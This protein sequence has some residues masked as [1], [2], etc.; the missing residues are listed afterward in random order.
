MINRNSVL[1][2]AEA[3]VNHN[4]DMQLAYQLIDAAVDAG[5]DIVKFQTF[6]TELLVNKQAKKADYQI[7]NTGNHNSS[8]Y[9][10]LK[11]LELTEEQHYQLA[12]YCKQKGIKFW[13]TAFDIESVHFLKSMGITLGK[14]PSGEITNLPYLQAMAANFDTLIVSTGMCTTEEVEAAILALENAGARRDKITILHCTTEYPAPLQDVHLNA[15]KAMGNYF[16]MQY[17]YSDHTE[18]IAIPIAAVA[19]GATVIEKHFTLNKNLPGPDHKA[20]LEPHELKAMVAGIRAVEKALGTNLKQPSEVELK[21]KLV[22]RKSICAATD[23]PQGTLIGETHLVMLRPGTGISPM[24][25]DKVL[26]K[27]LQINLSAGTP[28]TWEMLA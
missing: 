26:G 21:N 4:G 20:S 8:Q 14:I 22:A 18:G 2:I 3:G 11:Q 7:A 17:G 10:M 1:I 27:K 13:S 12:A 23:L 5:V 15:M 19:L 28:L 25:L 9:D 24:D 6:K 16:N